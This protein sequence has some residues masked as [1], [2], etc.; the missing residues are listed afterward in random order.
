M[1]INVHII[2]RLADYGV[3]LLFVVVS[4]MVG[5]TTGV[6]MSRGY[7]GYQTATPA[8]Y[9]TTTHECSGVLHH[10]GSGVLHHSS[11]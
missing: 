11:C 1:K 8:S 3:V 6:P 9:Q 10:E 2:Y 7:G 5:S 4:L